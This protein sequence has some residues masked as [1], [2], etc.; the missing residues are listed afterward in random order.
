M[1]SLSPNL[2]W[3]IT[4]TFAALGTGSLVRL[5]TLRRNDSQTAAKRRAALRTWW[6]LVILLTAAT[7]AGRL[8]ICLLLATASW[9]AL[10]EYAGL[11]ARRASDRVGVWLAL[12]TVPVNYL[13]ILLDQ[14]AA[15][16]VFVPLA[17]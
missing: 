6:I 4:A 9:L 14:Q 17:A 7:L 16:L 13:L 10:R 11:I 12:G 1:P 15:F 8:G 2:I 3:T 5:L